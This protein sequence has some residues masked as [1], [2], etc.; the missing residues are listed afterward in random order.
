MAFAVYRSPRQSKT[1]DITWKFHGQLAG[2][3]IPPVLGMYV[4][5][6][7]PD[8]GVS[9]RRAVWRYVS[10]NINEKLKVCKM[11]YNGDSIIKIA[12]TMGFTKQHIHMF[13]K[14]FPT[15]EQVDGR[16]TRPSDISPAQVELFCREYLM[17]KSAE[18]ISQEFGVSEES[19]L[20]LLYY[21]RDK[22]TIQGKPQHYAVIAKWMK[23]NG[24]NQK[25]F[26][27]ALCIPTTKLTSIFSGYS[28]LDADLGQRIS[29]MTG[30]PMKTI[31]EEMLK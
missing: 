30:I 25:M 31:Y 24:Y 1:C 28:H 21:I 4:C 29:D 16:V 14:E 26:S 23:Q 12:K 11:R 9:L 13:I 19:V 6:T 8:S 18:E 17:G 3:A 5:C 7:I 20:N 10:L 15:R 2:M 27:K 22:K